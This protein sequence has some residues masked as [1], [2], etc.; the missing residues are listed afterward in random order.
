MTTNE[1]TSKVL[2]VWK[3]LKALALGKRKSTKIPLFPNSQRI[4]MDFVCQTKSTWPAGQQLDATLP[5]ANPGLP[6]LDS[7][8]KG[9]K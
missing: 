3:A 1:K 8:L 5:G 4:L 2:K 7:T 9:S 6:G